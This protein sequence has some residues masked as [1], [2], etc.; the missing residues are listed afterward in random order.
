MPLQ[1]T[2]L[3]VVHNGILPR[4]RQ[5]GA[6]AA[7]VGGVEKRVGIAA[8]F[9]PVQEKVPHGILTCG[10][11]VGIAPHIVFGVEQR[12][13]SKELRLSGKPQP[14]CC[15]S[16][17]GCNP[18]PGFRKNPGQALRKGPAAAMAVV[19]RR[20]R[21]RFHPAAKVLDMAVE[22]EEDGAAFLDFD[23][24]IHQASPQL[25]EFIFR[26]PWMRSL[27]AVPGRYVFFCH[28]ASC[29]PICQ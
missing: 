9:G 7:I 12:G 22:V 27:R 28:A 5:L 1:G 20:F 21:R 8:L 10:S 29:L 16:E 15:V 6:L 4:E 25:V 11:Y 19:F 17:R 23:L 3:Q 14:G 13:F 24:N 18:P 2:L 26:S